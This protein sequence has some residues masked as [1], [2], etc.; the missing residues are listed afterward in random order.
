M[1]ILG[2]SEEIFSKYLSTVSIHNPELLIRTSGEYSVSNFLFWENAYTELYL[3]ET[4]WPDFEK[5]EFYKA[6]LDYQNRE[7]RYGKTS[8]Q[9]TN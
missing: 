5:E 4:L 6:L 9:L 7:K 1:T 8:E 3:T 2:I